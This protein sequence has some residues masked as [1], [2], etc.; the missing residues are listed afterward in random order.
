MIKFLLIGFMS[1]SFCASFE[2]SQKQ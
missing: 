1:A 2:I